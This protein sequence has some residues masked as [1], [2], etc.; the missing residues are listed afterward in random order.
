MTCCPTTAPTSSGGELIQSPVNGSSV[1]TPM[2]CDAEADKPRSLVTVSVTLKLPLDRNVCVTLRPVELDVPSPQFHEYEV[3]EVALVPTT[4][5]EASKL[6]G[7]FTE[8][9]VGGK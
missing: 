7:R 3:I 2:F 9:G 8:T 6:I 1:L 4:L 5:L